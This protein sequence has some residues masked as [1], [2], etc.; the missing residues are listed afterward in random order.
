MTNQPA[1]V[2]DTDIDLDCD[3]AAALAV[4]HALSD[5]NECR[6]L[7]VVCSAPIAACVG[8][9]RAINAACGRPD[10][11]VGS[12]R[13]PD[14]DVAPSW[15][16]YRTGR[17]TMPDMLYNQILAATRPPD[18]PA[19]EDAVSLYRRLLAAAGRRSVTI[20]AIGTLTA[21]AQLVLS[22][23]DAHSPLSGRD[24][25]AAKVAELVSMAVAP[26]PSG[27][28]VFNW[29][30]DLDSAATVIRDWPTPLTVSGH[31]STVLTGAAMNRAATPG[32]PVRVAYEMRA[33]GPGHSRSSW[34]QI[35]ALYAVRGVTRGPFRLGVDRGLTLN[36]ETGIHHWTDR[37]DPSAAIRREV[38]PTQP[39][40]ELAKLIEDLMLAAVCPKAKPS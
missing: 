20:C 27:S 32:H 13:V 40:A 39:D 24:L 37:A 34:D 2:L 6:L 26:Y 4:L 38:T 8:A 5:V 10:V 11:P 23:P 22:G 28:E 7:G 14:Y 25:V 1:I 15:L 29:K 21:L 17:A 16:A 3:D 33:N 36:P 35:A 19:P 31:G 12:V 18:D 30:M 9:A